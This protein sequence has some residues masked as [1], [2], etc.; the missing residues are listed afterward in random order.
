[1]TRLLEGLDIENKHFKS[2]EIGNFFNANPVATATVL[3]T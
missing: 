3:Q 1:M 2:F